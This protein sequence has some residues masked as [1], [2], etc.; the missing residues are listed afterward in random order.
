MCRTKCAAP[1]VPHQVCRTKCAAPS[2]PH[3][4]CRAKCAAPCAVAWPAPSRAERDLRAS[5]THLEE[6]SRE[7][8]DMAAY[9][10]EA[11]DRAASRAGACKC[12]PA[13]RLGLA[14][15]RAACDAI[16]STA[17]IGGPADPPAETRATAGSANP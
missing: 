8:E 15:L 16:L 7:L 4:V 9:L 1:N 13:D 2:V 11:H 14:P 6:Q 3:Q 5:K 10:V 12:R 17:D